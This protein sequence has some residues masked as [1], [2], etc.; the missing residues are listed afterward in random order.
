M[1]GMYSIV[2]LNLL[3]RTRSF[4]AW[5]SL[6]RRGISFGRYWPSASM[7]TI[8]SAPRSRLL[9]I[10]VRN[11]SAS[12]ALRGWECTAAPALRASS[13]VLSVLPSSTTSTLYLK[14]YLEASI[15]FWMSLMTPPS[16]FPSLYAG[17]VMMTSIGPERRCLFKYVFL[18]LWGRL[19]NHRGTH[20]PAGSIISRAA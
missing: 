4:P 7:C 11:V 18:L 14:L 8:M 9:L 1:R 17:M 16:V 5:T 3:P 20:C 2:P 13:A 12:P 19:L 10:S 6:I 15:T